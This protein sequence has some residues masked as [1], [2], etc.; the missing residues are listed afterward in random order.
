MYTYRRR[1]LWIINLTKKQYSER[2]KRYYLIKWLA[3]A[4]LA[5]KPLGYIVLHLVLQVYLKT[6]KEI[7]VHISLVR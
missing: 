3:V 7:E 2:H 4:H 5:L 6:P 1:L